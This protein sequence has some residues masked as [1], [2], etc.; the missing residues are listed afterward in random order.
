[1]S[2][3]FSYND[4]NFTVINNVLILHAKIIKDIS[5]N[6][7]FVEIP[8]EIFNRMDYYTYVAISVLDRLNVRTASTITIGVEDIDGRKY[9]YTSKAL[10]KDTTSSVIALFMLKDI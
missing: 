5:M 10:S 7:E 8:P 9:F 1:M 6:E 3:P 4:E 2:R